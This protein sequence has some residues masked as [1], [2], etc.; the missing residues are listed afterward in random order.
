MVDEHWM[1]VLITRHHNEAATVV[2]KA[3]A[4]YQ[5]HWDD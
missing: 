4:A 1:I 5:P 2:S 3:I